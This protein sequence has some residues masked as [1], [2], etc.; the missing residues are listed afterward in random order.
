MTDSTI[1]SPNFATRRRNRWTTRRIYLKWAHFDPF[2][3][4]NH[5]ICTLSS[6]K[7][8]KSQ[9]M[10]MNTSTLRS[11]PIFRVLWWWLLN[12]SIHYSIRFSICSTSPSF[13]VTIYEIPRWA[14]IQ[15]EHLLHPPRAHYYL[16]RGKIWYDKCSRRKDYSGLWCKTRWCVAKYWRT[17]NY[18]EIYFYL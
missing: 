11:R 9:P 5:R 8:L 16:C 13:P 15:V 14:L 2:P 6:S 17:C 18:Q 10:N 3:C 4:P 1:P 7:I 12:S